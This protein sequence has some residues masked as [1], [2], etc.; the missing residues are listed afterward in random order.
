MVSMVLLAECGFAN[1]EASKAMT[2]LSH[3][4]LAEIGLC[5]ICFMVLLNGV[6]CL[7]VVSVQ[8]KW[9]Y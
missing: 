8:R 7:R 3:R 4:V 2:A 9:Q 6:A 1:R 5:T